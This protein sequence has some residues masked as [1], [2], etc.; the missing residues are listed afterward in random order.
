MTNAATPSNEGP[1]SNPLEVID[2]IADQFR[3]MHD[4]ETT[5][6]QRAQTIHKLTGQYPDLPRLALTWA[7]LAEEIHLQQIHGQILSDADM[8]QLYPHDTSVVHEARHQ[9][10]EAQL[11]LAPRMP[12]A[13]K[14]RNCRAGNSSPKSR[15][16]GLSG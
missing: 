11:K 15:D 10:A 9:N 1:H 4:R 16:I 12:T 7:V 2:R 8:L 3:S 13:A 5:P 6:Q 14:P